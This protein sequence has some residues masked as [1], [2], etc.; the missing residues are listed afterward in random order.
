MLFLINKSIV[1]KM[2]DIRNIYLE[3]IRDFMR[4][5]EREDETELEDEEPWTYNVSRLKYSIEWFISFE[6]AYN[7]C[8]GILDVTHESFQIMPEFATTFAEKEER[9]DS[10]RFSM[11]PDWQSRNVTSRKSYESTGTL[12]TQAA[13]CQNFKISIG[14]YPKFT[15]KAKDWISFERKFR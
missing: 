8:P 2:G 10:M 6:R 12:G 3:D 13:R 11:S 5:Y 15:V 4:D 9:R 1:E 7:R 14:D